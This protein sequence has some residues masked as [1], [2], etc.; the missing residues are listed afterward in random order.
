M[1]PFQYH[2]E[3]MARH[4]SHLGDACPSFTWDGRPYNIIPGT[5]VRR[6]DLDRG[7]YALSS[8]LQLHVL[9]SAFSDSPPSLKE[10]ISYLGNDYRL[11]EI[12]PL[13]GNLVWKLVLNDA[14]AG[15]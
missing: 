5:A 6:Q 10:I 2:A 7:G 1:S 12:Q 8:D 13:P 3:V 11:D 15:V 14:T 9:A 4:Q